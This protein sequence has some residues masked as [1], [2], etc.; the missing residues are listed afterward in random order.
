MKGI[1]IMKKHVYMAPATKVQEIELLNLM[2][3]SEGPEKV[4]SNPEDGI[5]TESEILSR[6]SF[7]NDEE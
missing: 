1:A 7:W 6:R 5:E 3:G 2:A 4:Y